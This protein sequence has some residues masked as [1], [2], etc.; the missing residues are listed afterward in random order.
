[1]I[2]ERCEFLQFFVPFSLGLLILVCAANA[3]A[4]HPACPQHERPLVDEVVAVQGGNE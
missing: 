1:M 4:D 3:K 2:L